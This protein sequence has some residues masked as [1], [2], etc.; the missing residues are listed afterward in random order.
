MSTLKSTL[1]RAVPWPVIHMARRLRGYWRSRNY[2]DPTVAERALGTVDADWRWRIDDVRACPDNAF[3]PRV[4]DAGTL[5]DGLI[6]MHNGIKVSALGYYGAGTMNMLAEN[7]GVHEPQEE[8]AFAEVLKHVPAGGSMLELGAYWGFYSV[9]F[10]K[11]VERPQNYLLEPEPENLKSARE[12]FR[13]NGASAVFDSAY[14]GATDGRA[15][16]GTPTV[17]VDTFCARH[18]IDR[19]TI[20]HSDIQGF[21]LDMLRGAE[22]MLSCGN[23]DYVFISTHSNELHHACAD[24]LKAHGYVVLASAD[25]DETYSVDGLLVAKRAA[26]EGPIE[27][28]ITRKPVAGREATS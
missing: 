27:V 7:R 24:A 3:I 18:G 8:R 11:T 28:P 9:W 16:N 13:I 10:A 17:T 20:L 23:I 4:P 26:V 19:L 15:D 14:V 1:K 6:T 21:E 12:N 22:R 5:K 2:A 25:L